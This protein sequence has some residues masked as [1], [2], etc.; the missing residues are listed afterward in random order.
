MAGTLAPI[1][2]TLLLRSCSGIGNGDDLLDPRAGAVA[3]DAERD[4]AGHAPRAVARGGAA[5]RAARGLQVAEVEARDVALGELLLVGG[6]DRVT[7][8]LALPRHHALG[9]GG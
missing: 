8:F 7:A 1:A 3:D 6:G 5:D 2:A 9:V 4:L